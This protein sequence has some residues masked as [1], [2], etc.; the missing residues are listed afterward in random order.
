MKNKELRL[1][2]K[3]EEVEDRNNK[4][5][6]LRGRGKL[7]GLFIVELIVRQICIKGLR[8]IF[9]FYL[10]SKTR[11]IQYVNVKVFI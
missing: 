11:K 6:F 10:Y 8:D 2:N 7:G 5:K 4:K 1:I 3:Q 9:F